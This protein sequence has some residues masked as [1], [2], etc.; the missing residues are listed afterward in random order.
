M[1]GLTLGAVLGSARSI[2]SG[3]PGEVGTSTAARFDRAFFFGDLNYR[4]DGHTRTEAIALIEEARPP[5][6]GA[7]LVAPPRAQARPSTG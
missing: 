7:T 5:A 2:A 6:A 3:A 4:I 1:L